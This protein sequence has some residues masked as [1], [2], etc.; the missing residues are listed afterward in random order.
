MSTKGRKVADNTDMALSR[1][2]G[3]LGW[4]SRTNW[5]PLLEIGKAEGEVREQGRGMKVRCVVKMT[6]FLWW[7]S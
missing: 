1:I 4:M 2:L 5:L 6:D 7:L 3:F